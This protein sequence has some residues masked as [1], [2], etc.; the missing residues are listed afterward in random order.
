MSNSSK[1][2]KVSLS[3]DGLMGSQPMQFTHIWAFLSGSMIRL[4]A[5]DLSFEDWALRGCRWMRKTGVIIRHCSRTWGGCTC[6]TF[7]IAVIVLGQAIFRSRAEARGSMPIALNYHSWPW[8]GVLLF[9][10]IAA[11]E[12]GRKQPITTSSEQRR[13][14]QPRITFKFASASGSEKR[15]VTCI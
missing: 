14:P 10:T 4:E 6:Y 13:K 9:T 11:R 8:W 15:Y 1:S 5:M 12:R 2:R 3:P 7:S